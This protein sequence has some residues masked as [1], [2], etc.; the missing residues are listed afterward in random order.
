MIT[1]IF[2]TST[3]HTPSTKYYIKYLHNQKGELSHTITNVTKLKMTDISLVNGRI[4]F[5]TL[6]SHTQNGCDQDDDLI[7]GTQSL[8]QCIF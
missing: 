8:T 2:L 6:P 7:Y 3:T 4:V 5:K 1:E